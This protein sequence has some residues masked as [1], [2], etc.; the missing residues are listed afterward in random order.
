M[1][2]KGTEGTKGTQGTQRTEM[3]PAF[4]SFGSFP[5]SLSGAG[6]ETGA[7]HA[8]AQATLSEKS[9]FQPAELLVEE[10]VS[11]F[12]QAH[13]HIDADRG[14][15]VLDALFERFFVYEAVAEKK[16]GLI[17]HQGF[18]VGEEFL[19]AAVGWD[20]ALS[21]TRRKGPKGRGGTGARWCPF[22]R[23]GHFG[24]SVRQGLGFSSLVER[25]L[26][27][28]AGGITR[29]SW[30]ALCSDLFASVGEGKGRKGPK[31]RK[32]RLTAA[33]DYHWV[34][35]PR[36]RDLR[37]GGRNLRRAARVAK[38]SRAMSA[39][40]GMALMSRL[41]LKSVLSSPGDWS[42]KKRVQVPLGLKPLK[43]AREEREVSR[44][45]ARPSACQVPVSWP[46][47][48]YEGEKFW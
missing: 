8:L 1:G 19:V 35:E 14:V 43:S 4:W 18:L 31:R 13:N 29:K 48:L 11:H 17:N 42:A 15:G 21:I 40:S 9:L 7:G 36:R 6:G 28:K 45:L 22:G 27:P 37:R 33:A 20:E 39:R 32:G 26:R 34:G 41:Q 10:V 23:F 38:M 12:D 46:L 3:S 2:G 16:G 30:A 5:W 25:H 44:G 47:P 24:L